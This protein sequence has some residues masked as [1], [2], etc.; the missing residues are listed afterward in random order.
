[1]LLYPQCACSNELD[2]CSQFQYI[3]P[4]NWRE[5]SR[6]RVCLPFRILTVEWSGARSCLFWWRHRFQIASFSSSALDNRVFKM[7]RFQIA[8][9]WRA[10][11]N[12]SVFGD[13]FRRCSVDDSRIRS[14]TAPR[15]FEN[16]LV[17]TGPKKTTTAT[18]TGTSLNKRFNEKNSGSARA[19]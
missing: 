9:L 7:H 14:K 4:R 1:M 19:L 16:G 11:S 6:A 12:G 5:I 2:A 18:T 13:H 8:P 3:G 15:S 10:F 17:W